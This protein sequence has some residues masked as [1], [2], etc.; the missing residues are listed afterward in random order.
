L[1]TVAVP[2]RAVD[3]SFGVR[4]FALTNALNATVLFLAKLPLSAER[5]VQKFALLGN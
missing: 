5:H 1:G 4:P 3:V 2:E